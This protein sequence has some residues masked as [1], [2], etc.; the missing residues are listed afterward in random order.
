M[1]VGKEMFNPLKVKLALVGVLVGTGL[2]LAQ[3]P[4][5]TLRGVDGSSF[6]LAGNR[7]KV[8]VLS[9]GSTAVPLV[10]KELPAFQKLADRYAGRDV[11]FY[12]VSI[13]AAAPGARNYISD[14][15][16]QAFAQKDGLRL[17]VLRD[18]ERAASRAFGVDALPTVV[19]IDRAG[20]VSNKQV[21]FDPERGE[22]YG[23]VIRMVDQLLK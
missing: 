9:F 8:I 18:P 5:V 20:Q 16:L 14:A 15:D 12:W 23:D 19:I 7:G 2:A 21:G 13:N 11:A 3:A 4:Q 17:P 1:K 6:S 10:A 22:G